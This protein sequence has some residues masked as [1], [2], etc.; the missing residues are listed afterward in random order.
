MFQVGNLSVLIFGAKQNLTKF[1]AYLYINN[2]LIINQ[3]K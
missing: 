3:L 1:E 2:L